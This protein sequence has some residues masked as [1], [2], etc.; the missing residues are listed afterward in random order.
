M[1]ERVESSMYFTCDRVSVHADSTE[2]AVFFSVP[3]LEISTNI[4]V[5]SLADKNGS[6]PQVFE[7]IEQSQARV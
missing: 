7:Q 4:R 2:N 5:P 1:I 6:S 3:D